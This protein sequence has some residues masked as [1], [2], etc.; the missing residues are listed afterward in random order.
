MIITKADRRVIYENLFKEGVLVAKKDFN[1]PK[2]AELDV[3]NLHVIKACQSLTSMGY[4]TT[5]F[6][7]QYYYYV[8]TPEGIDY[9]REYLHL[10]A[11]I[12]P[13]TFKKAVRAP[14]PG[15]A[16][17]PEGAYRA[18]R[19]G[20]DDGYRR[21]DDK[22]EGAGEDFRPRFSGVGRGGPRPAEA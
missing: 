19:Q 10:P 4:L 22:K 3:K 12:V 15:Q 20:G 1:A 17:R 14:R 7:W 8:L 9:L 11:E 16:S 2:H 6:S 13:A 18:P 5:Q 21:R